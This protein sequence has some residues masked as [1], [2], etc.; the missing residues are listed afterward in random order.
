MTEPTSRTP[1]PTQPAGEPGPD[2]AQRPRGV[3]EAAPALQES[4]AALS[5]DERIE[6]IGVLWDSLE[7][8]EAA[9]IS[10]ELA[11]ELARREAEAD[12]DPDG[13]V[14]WEAL[15]AELRARLR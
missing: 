1:H 2:S 7:P 8:S 3:R 4:V 5:V 15:Q 6:L 12:A 14:S 13:G 9:P 10:T 11:A